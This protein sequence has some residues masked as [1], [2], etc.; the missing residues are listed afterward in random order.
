MKDKLEPKDEKIKVKLSDQ[1]KDS[2]ILKMGGVIALN[3]NSKSYFN[4]GG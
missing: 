2:I 1:I 4:S 3:S